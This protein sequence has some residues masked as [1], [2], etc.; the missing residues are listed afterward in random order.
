MAKTESRRFLLIDAHDHETSEVYLIP[1]NDPSSEPILI[2]EREN[3]VEYSVSEHDGRLI[4]LT[5]ADG[6]EDFKIVTASIDN[7]SMP[8]QDWK[9]DHSPRK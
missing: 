1:A 7:P 3:G 2:A 8:V 6:A 9:V 4:I 5:N